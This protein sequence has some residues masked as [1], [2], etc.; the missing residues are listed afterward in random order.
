MLKFFDKKN[1]DYYI[2]EGIIII[3][4]TLNNTMITLTNNVGDTIFSSS[5]GNFGFKGSRKSTS[6]A[7]QI[8][9][10]K[11]ASVAKQFGF[12]QISIILKGQGTAR[13]VAFQT[14]QNKRFHINYLGDFT[15]IPHN[16]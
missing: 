14:I 12:K 2:K 7:S 3:N 11:V 13:E 1:S 5:S 16:G 8:I 4:S 15:P 10:E 9:A 6:F